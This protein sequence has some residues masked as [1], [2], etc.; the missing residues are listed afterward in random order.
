MIVA[1]LVDEVKRGVQDLFV[2]EWLVGSCSDVT[3]ILNLFDQISK[4]VLASQGLYKS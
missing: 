2:G 4:G 3:T 1:G